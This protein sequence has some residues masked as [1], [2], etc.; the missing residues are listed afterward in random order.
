MAF[1][2]IQLCAEARVLLYASPQAL[3]RGMV[4]SLYMYLRSSEM[5][6]TPWHSRK[7][8]LEQLFFLVTEP[9]CTAMLSLSGAQ[10]WV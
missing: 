10:G 1:L 7:R 3:R 5:N 9:F 6:N 2:T 4:L 8:F